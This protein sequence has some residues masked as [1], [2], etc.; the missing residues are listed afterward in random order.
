MDTAAMKWAQYRGAKVRYA[1][2]MKQW[3]ALS[4]ELADVA[5]E[6]RMALDD[7]RETQRLEDEDA[8]AMCG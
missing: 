8:R 2:V 4:G 6:V 3:R 7:A 1:V 5:R